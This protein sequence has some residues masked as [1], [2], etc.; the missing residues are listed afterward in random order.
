[1]TRYA[2]PLAAILAGA[3]AFAQPQTAPAGPGPAA[4]ASPPTAAAE[5]SGDAAYGAYQRGNFLTAIREALA[6]IERNPQDGAAMTLLGVIYAQGAGVPLDPKGAAIWFRRGHERGDVNA[7]FALAMATLRGEGVERDVAAGRALLEKAV[8]AGHGA[9]CYNLALILIPSDEFN[10]QARAAALLRR[11]ANQEIADAQY[12]LSVLH[13][14]GR[15]VGVNLEEARALLARAARSGPLDSI[16]D[17][18]IMVFNGEGGP[19][20]EAAGAGLLRQAAHRGHAVAQ[21]RLARLH[22]AGRGVPPSKVEAAAWHMLAS[23]AGL[24]DDWLDRE[25]DGLSPEDR[26]A[27]EKLAR[28]RSPAS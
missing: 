11:A 15:G 19:R 10:D 17:L 1:M 3:P 2:L 24:K 9:A 23:G 27:A 7:T 14:E 25:L 6:R 26:A 16:V 5:P 18:A 12:A 4:P 20:D 28:E 13:R 8:E 22:V 21:N